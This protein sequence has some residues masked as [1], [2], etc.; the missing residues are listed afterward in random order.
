MEQE[1]LPIEFKAEPENNATVEVNI[2]VENMESKTNG[3]CTE[4]RFL[5]I[6]IYT[7]TITKSSFFKILLQLNLNLY[8]L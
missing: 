3:D 1:V 4:V 2:E 8:L 5:L 7:I 6:Y